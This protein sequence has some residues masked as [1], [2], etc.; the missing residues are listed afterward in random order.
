MNI[1]KT[2]HALLCFVVVWNETFTHIF[3]DYF[4]DTGAMM[5]VSK[6]LN[7]SESGETITYK[8]LGFS[9]PLTLTRSSYRPGPDIRVACKNHPKC[10]EMKSGREEILVNID[11]ANGLY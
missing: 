7:N 9:F 1:T 11:S 4:I 8:G 6:R 3:Q 10:V 5:Y 2:V